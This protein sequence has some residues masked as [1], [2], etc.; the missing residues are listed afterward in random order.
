MT[1]NL[2]SDCL[3]YS[4]NVFQALPTSASN[5]K[6]NAVPKFRLERYNLSMK[7]HRVDKGLMRGDGIKGH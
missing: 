6:H 2:L 5:I 4:N 3:Q 1:N 7:D